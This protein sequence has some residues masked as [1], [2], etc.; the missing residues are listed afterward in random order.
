M[1][2]YLALAVTLMV[3]PLTSFAAPFVEGTHYTQISNNMVPTEPK[4]TEFFS[5]YCHNC[6]NME[7]QYLPEIKKGLDKRVAFDSKHVDFMNSDLGTEVMRSLA[8]IHELDNKEALKI[9]MFSAIQGKDNNAGHD[10]NAA[11]HEHKSLI[12]S[13]DDIKKVFAEL[14]VDA[15]Q[16]DTLADSTETDQKLALWRQQQDMYAVQSVPAF[17]VNDKY[18]INLNEM[19]SLD[20]I[21]GLIN[22]LALKQ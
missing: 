2:K 10:H 11:G 5:F 8:V 17:I 21:I 15:K 16:Y 20:D 18:A 1:F 13:R 22:Y 4:V 12:N 14:G 6:F 9:A 7:S 3:T 19:R